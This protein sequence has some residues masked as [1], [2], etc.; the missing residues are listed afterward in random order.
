MQNTLF[1]IDKSV[2]IIMV[3][4][5]LHG[6]LESF[7]HIMRCWREEKCSLIIFLGDFADRGNQGVEITES[8][9]KLQQNEDVILLKGN[10]E[11]YLDN[12]NPTFSPCSFIEEVQ[13]KRGS[14]ENYF[15][16]TLK[17]FY[18]RLYLSALLEG[19][20]LFLHGGISNKIKDINSLIKPTREVE[21]DILWSD[22]NEH[23]FDEQVNHRGMGVEFGERIL[24]EI[25]NRLN[26]QLIIRS[27]QPNLAKD[28]PYMFRNKLMTISSTDIY[29]GIAHFLKI[30]AKTMEYT[31]E[32]V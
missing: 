10:H 3:V 8:L 9:I 1:N 18:D 11:N 24:T 14:W 30:D 31:T 15:Q 13:S 4:G 5:D 25:M 19:K 2:E 20:F 29:G 26:I 16:T 27:H 32:F 12:G 23:I 17:P 28:K 21:E 7:N 22:P 6:D